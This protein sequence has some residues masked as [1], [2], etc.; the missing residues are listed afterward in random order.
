MGNVKLNAQMT[1]IRIK[2]T[3]KEK[4]ASNEVNNVVYL[5]ILENNNQKLTFFEF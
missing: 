2:P 5:S 4:H 3:E 1:A